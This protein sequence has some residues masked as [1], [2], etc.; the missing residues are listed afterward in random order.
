MGKID[1]RAHVPFPNVF[2]NG[3]R[4]CEK[5]FLN[6]NRVFRVAIFEHEL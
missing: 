2:E 3:C 1:H 5:A 4:G 6:E